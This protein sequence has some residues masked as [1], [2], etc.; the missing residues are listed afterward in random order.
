MTKRFAWLALLAVLAG[1]DTRPAATPSA[2]PARV[3][4]LRI[5]SSNPRFPAD[6][7]DG[8]ANDASVVVTGRL[9]LPAAV[10]G[11][12]PVMVIVHGSGGIGSRGAEY[13]R[14]LNAIGIGTLRTDSF[15]PRGV[16]TTVGDQRAVSTYSMVADALN[17]LKLLAS[18]PRVDPDRI[19]IMGFSKGGSTAFL[20]AFEPFRSAVIGPGPKF[21]VHLPFYRGCLYDVSMPLTGAPVRE[22]IGDSDD[23]TGVATCVAYAKKRRAEGYDYRAIV[24]PGA[25]HA[26]NMSRAPFRCGR[27]ISF[28]NCHWSIGDD[29]RILD[30]KTGL[31]YTPGN[32]GRILTCTHRGTTVGRNAEAARASRRFVVD[33]LGKVFE[34]PKHGRG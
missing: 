11:K 9:S 15:G 1:C 17:A 3:S 34:L 31:E 27:C 16:T 6:L 2:E 26:F 10:S 19:G 7:L 12:L 23:Y 33:Y 24:F 20:T 28:A 21:A 14:V 8:P 18:D 4:M 30:R 32:R 13:E 5:A 22:L 29:G 25:H